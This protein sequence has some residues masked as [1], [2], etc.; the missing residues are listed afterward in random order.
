MAED[1]VSLAAF[2]TG[3]KSFDAKR[4]LQEHGI[5][6]VNVWPVHASAYGYFDR[7]HVLMIA[8]S[9]LS[10]ARRLLAENGLLGDSEMLRDADRHLSEDA[11]HLPA[12]WRPFPESRRHDILNRAAVYSF[13]AIV[14]VGGLFTASRDTS[15]RLRLLRT[16]RQSS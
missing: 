4:V 9:C 10:P 5:A 11:A 2:K 14:I 6:E 13:V 16:G 12:R 8:K 15:T 7:S 1:Y 3:R